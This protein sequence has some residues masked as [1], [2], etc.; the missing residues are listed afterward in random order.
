MTICGA[1]KLI[2]MIVIGG[3]HSTS[4]IDAIERTLD[5]AEQRHN[6]MR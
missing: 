3:A 4:V 5:R 2:V 1:L 6:R